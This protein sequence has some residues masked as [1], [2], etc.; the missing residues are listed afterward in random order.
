MRS[1]RWILPKQANRRGATAVEA[2]IV[3][4][5]LFAVL[6][7]ILDLG[8]AATRYNAIAEV[9]HRVAREAVLHG[10]LSEDSADMWGPSEYSGTLADG[11]EVMATAANMIPTMDASDVRVRV[12]WPDVDN[13]PRDRVRVDV[14][15]DHVPLVPLF[16]PWGTLELRSTATMHVVN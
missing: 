3:L 8:I 9:A 13:S 14:E 2:A 5:V 4:P 7:A 15:Y 16:C 11:S 12:S 6:F 1:D 10:S